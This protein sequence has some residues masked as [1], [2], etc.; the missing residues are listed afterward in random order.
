MRQKHIAFAAFALLFVAVI[1]ARPRPPQQSPTYQQQLDALNEAY[2]NGLLTQEEYA[3]KLRQLNGNSSTPAYGAAPPSSGGPVAMTT[4]TIFDPFFNHDFVHV[5]MPANWIFQG[6]IVP[7]NSCS[8]SASPVYRI[9]SPDGLSGLKVF[10]V[11]DLGWSNDPRLRPNGSGGCQAFEGDPKAWDVIQ[12]LA[13]LVHVQNVKD[14]TDPARVEQF[15][16]TWARY[17]TASYANNFA[18]VAVALASFHINSIAEEER[19]V[20]RVHCTLSTAFVMKGTFKNHCSVNISLAWAPQGKLQSTLALLQP[21]MDV[22]YDP[23]WERRWK[24][25]VDQQAEAFRERDNAYWANM[26]RSNNIFYANL[27]NTM[28]QNHQQFMQQ[29]SSQFAQHEAQIAQMQRA[30]DMNLVNTMR[31]MDSQHRMNEDLCDS[32][33]GQQR[34]LNPQTGET[35][36]TENATYDWVNSAGKHYLTDYINDNPNGI[37][38][39]TDYVLTQNVHN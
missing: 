38:G 6:G 19:L 13:A 3:A 29:Q 37:N 9:S 33:L 35:Y 21:A 7:G 11:I 16:N 31:N 27:R 34:R 15:R 26:A 22:P 8:G 32:I 39:R 23:E 1:R 24:Q 12:W 28:N 5:P 36:K 10:P 2:R 25:A 14:I 17:S 30:G 4:A 20:V 18:D